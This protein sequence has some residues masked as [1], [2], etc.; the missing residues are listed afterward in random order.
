[1]VKKTKPPEGRAV[2]SP[3]E[4]CFYLNL[5][6][7]SLKCLIREGEVRTIRVGR[8]YLIPKESLDD[9]INRDRLIAKAIL[10][11]VKQV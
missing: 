9:F 6:W 3:G 4:A 8:R 5:S 1:M 10:K 7:N 11:S 2:F